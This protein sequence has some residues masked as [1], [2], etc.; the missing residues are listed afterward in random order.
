MQFSQVNMLFLMRLII[1]TFLIL[2]INSCGNKKT[3]EEI[4]KLISINNEE[5]KVRILRDLAEFR[6]T[7]M[8]CDTV[9]Q[10]LKQLENEL[11]NLRSF[12]YNTIK[13]IK[14]TEKSSQIKLEY[15]EYYDSLTKIEEHLSI[16]PNSVTRINFNIDKLDLNDSEFSKQILINSMLWDEFILLHKALPEYETDCSE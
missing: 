10:K 5:L 7:L 2:L 15:Q 8:D 4:I 14:S 6:I 13:S 16:Q 12:T 9:D 1:L 11:I 3:D